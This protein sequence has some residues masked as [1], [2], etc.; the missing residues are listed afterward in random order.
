MSYR[1]Y[2]DTTPLIYFLDRSPF[3]Y[4]K[5]RDF[6]FE[7]INGCVAFILLQIFGL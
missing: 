5:M 3:Y 4:T 1:V 7:N 2:F 6:L